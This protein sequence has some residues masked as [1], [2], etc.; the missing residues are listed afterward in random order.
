MNCSYTIGTVTVNNHKLRVVNK[1]L[2]DLFETI[3]HRLFDNN[4]NV[5]GAP[6]LSHQ[7]KL[8]SAK[9][10]MVKIVLLKDTMKGDS[11]HVQPILGYNGCHH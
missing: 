4:I 7:L 3:E 10:C 5:F 1:G 2:F 6:V 9:K 8:I 11:G